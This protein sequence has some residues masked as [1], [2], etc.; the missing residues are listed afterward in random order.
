MWA[1]TRERFT[2]GVGIPQGAQPS[3][4]LANT[5]LHNLDNLL[6]SDALKYYRYMDDIRIYGYS[7]EDMIKALIKIDGY[8][9][10]FGFALNAKKTTIQ[11][12]VNDETDDSIIKFLEFYDE[13]RDSTQS[14]FI[15]EFSKLAEQDSQSEKEGHTIILT[16]KGDIKAFWI[17]ELK[18]VEK[19]LP[20]LFIHG[21]DNNT[22]ELPKKVEDREI[23][24]LCFKYRLALKN[25]NELS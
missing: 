3:F 22:L 21:E 13:D 14:T 16:N 12:V 18:Y 15:D 2:P 10:G 5:L 20:N 4:F 7:E 17:D 8:L 23:L 9:K 6:I 24:S 1:G 25:L 19:E 11:E